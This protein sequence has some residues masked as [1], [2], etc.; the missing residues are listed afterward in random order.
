MTQTNLNVIGL[1][2]GVGGIEL[3]FE[4]AG[5]KP[6]VANE[7]DAYAATTY[8]ELHKQPVFVAD[9]NDVTA[10]NLQDFLEEHGIANTEL[11]G[12]ILTGGFPCQPFSVAGHRKGFQD[13]R[14]N[15]FWQIHR[16]INEIQPEVD[17]FDDLI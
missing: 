9:I 10:K 15:V 14:G 8:R 3:G 1:F 4:K 17:E 2:A 13:P 6:L 16:L 7:I 11:K 5:F 12:S